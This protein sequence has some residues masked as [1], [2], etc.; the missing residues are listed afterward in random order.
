MKN[1]NLTSTYSFVRIALLEQLDSI[2][3][4]FS[5][6]DAFYFS[7]N[8]SYSIL[9]T[10]FDYFF[11]FHCCCWLVAVEFK[12][13]I[14][15]DINSCRTTHT[16]KLHFFFCLVE[17]YSTQND[18]TC[19][20]S[21]FNQF[22]YFLQF[23]FNFNVPSPPHSLCHDTWVCFGIWFAWI[24]CLM[25]AFFLSFLLRLSF[26]NRKLSSRSICR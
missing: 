12:N 7:F 13:S 16:L 25:I 1:I 4:K 17:S 19:Q 21:T 11:L 8:F 20:P 14:V 24:S 23:A 22:F 3:F 9:F 15:V 18:I 5:V 2:C 10:F 26:E 6:R